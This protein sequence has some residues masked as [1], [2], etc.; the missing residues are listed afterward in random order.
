MV[1]AANYQEIDGGVKVLRQKDET[2]N[3]K[4]ITETEIETK[5]SELFSDFQT[6][7]LSEQ[8]DVAVIPSPDFTKKNKSSVNKTMRFLKPDC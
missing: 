7:L 5:T 2:K 4:K 3:K 1:S 6:V 8:E